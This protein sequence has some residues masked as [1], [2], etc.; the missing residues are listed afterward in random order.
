MNRGKASKAKRWRA[1]WVAPPGAQ[2]KAPAKIYQLKATIVGIEPPVWRRLLVPSSMNLSQL[3][4]L[5]QSAFGWWD[6]HLHEF[7][8]GGTRY[9]K[10]GNDR[11]GPARR[12]ERYAR[13][14]AIVQPGLT[15]SYVYDF[16]DDWQ[17]ELV[18]EK[19]LDPVPGEQYPFCS[20]GEGACPPEDCGGVPGYLRSIGRAE[21]GT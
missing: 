3:H 13:L 8:V 2:K 9:G 21:S 5:L 16:G 7:E 18:V 12:S 14:A 17:H 4:E 15:F 20:A 6:C 10:E 1:E 19:E 11:W